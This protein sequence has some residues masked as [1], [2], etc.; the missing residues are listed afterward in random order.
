MFVD[1]LILAVVDLSITVPQATIGS[2]N[3]SVYPISPIIM[4]TKQVNM[5]QIVHYK[6]VTFVGMSCL[7]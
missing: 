6:V 7:R 3:F 5:G 2:I 1:G 4:A